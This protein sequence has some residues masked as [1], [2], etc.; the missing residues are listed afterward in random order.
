MYESLNSNPLVNYLT[1]HFL[2]EDFVT[3]VGSFYILLVKN[4][5]K[6]DYRSRMLLFLA[7]KPIGASP[8]MFS[9]ELWCTGS[10]FGHA[11]MVH[12]GGGQL[13]ATGSHAA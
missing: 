1:K 9:V 2:V 7:D 5:E 3:R 4:N 11:G 13:T 6:K 10:C 12:R 8:R